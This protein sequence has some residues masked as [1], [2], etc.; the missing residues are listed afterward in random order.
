[1][2]KGRIIMLSYRELEK[3]VD[4]Q[5]ELIERLQGEVSRLRAELSALR[6]CDCDI[7]PECISMEVVADGDIDCPRS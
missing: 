4:E 1:M 6:Q 3:L 2:T 7:L 5:T